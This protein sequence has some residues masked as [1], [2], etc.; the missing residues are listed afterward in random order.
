MSPSIRRDAIWRFFGI[1]IAY[2]VGCGTARAEELCPTGPFDT[3]VRSIAAAIAAEP[4]KPPDWYA[5]RATSNTLDPIDG[6]INQ[7][8]GGLGGHASSTLRYDARHYVVLL[9]D[10][11]WPDPNFGVVPEEPPKPGPNRVVR[12]VGN[13]TYSTTVSRPTPED[14]REF[15]CLANHLLMSSSPPDPAPSSPTE[16]IVSIQRACPEPSYT[17]EAYDSLALQSSRPALGYDNN[18]TC[19]IRGQ[20]KIHLKELMSAM[21]KEGTERAAGSWRPAHVRSLAI[22]AAD[23]LYLLLDPGSHQRRTMEIREVKHSGAVVRLS[24]TT[25]EVFSGGSLAVDGRGHAWVLTDETHQ[26]L[27]YDVPSDIHDGVAMQERL[28]HGVFPVQLRGWLASVAAAADGGLVA[29]AASELFAIAP[30]GTATLL[31]D[32][33]IWHQKTPFAFFNRP[34]NFV[35]GSDGTICVSDAI[36]SVILEMT[37]NGPFKILAGARHAAGSADGRGGWARFNAPEG[38]ALDR[39]G[40]LYVADS[41]NHTIRRITPDRHVSTLAGKAGKRGTVDGP[42]ASARLDTPTFIAVDSESVV[43]V[44][45]GT[46][47]LIRKISPAGLVS[48]VNAQQFIDRQ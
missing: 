36:D 48:T 10:E 24:T 4:A 35:R 28:F 37:P 47:N 23:N 42:G 31:A 26:I 41:G 7:S 14:A 33:D 38:L 25:R 5:D 34:L 9:V 40:N 8:G 15:A 1:I 17:D 2:L 44:T 19:E 45:N 32:A 20:L 12:K 22:D 43:Y 16:V 27:F 13:E 39:H 3:D 46:D 29:M 11:T 30:S 6:A 18:L 21:L